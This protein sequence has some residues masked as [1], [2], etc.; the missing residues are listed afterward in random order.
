MVGHFVSASGKIVWLTPALRPEHLC[1]IIQDFGF[2]S[3]VIGP[4][5]AFG[6]W[7]FNVAPMLF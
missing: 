6:E 1:G 5:Q 4:L 3:Y 2:G 7:R